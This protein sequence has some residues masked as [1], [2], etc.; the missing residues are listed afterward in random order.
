M[1]FVI[2]TGP[3]TNFS[4]AGKLPV[5][6]RLLSTQRCVVPPQVIAE[7]DRGPH[8]LDNQSALTASWI[9]TQPLTDEAHA[10]T[11][12]L[13]S[14]LGGTGD[15]NLGEAQCLA[16]ACTLPGVTYLDDGDGCA[17]ADR[18]G[19]G[20]TTTL[21]LLADGLEAGVLDA[22]EAADTVDALL[23]TGYRLPFS[24]G[25]SF[26]EALGIRPD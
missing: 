16:L 18:F 17:V 15:R 21:D 10:L 20:Y 6:C 14:E 19:V 22:D 25:A 7:L 2:D 8:R 24:S 11:L 4:Q 3:L 13:K 23:N 9:V 26:V 12:S 5:L 1:T